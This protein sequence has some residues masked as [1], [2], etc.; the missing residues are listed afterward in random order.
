MIDGLFDLEEAGTNIRT[1]IVA[2]VT[3]FMTMSYIIFVQPAVL[4]AAGMNPGAVMVATCLSSAIAMV[5]MAVLTNYPIALAPAMGH[6]FF[7]SYIVVLTLGYTWQVAL[8]SVFIAGLV[9]ILL[10]TVGLRE[11]LMIVLPDCLKNGIP[12]GIGLL[13]ALVGLEW[14]GIVVGHQVTYVTLGNLKSAPTL[15]S[16]FGL[17]LIALL[18]ALKIRGAILF[19]IIATSILGLLVGIIEFEGVISAPPSIMPTM[20]KLQFPN[21][22]KDPNLLTVIFIFLFLDMFDT[23]G[24]LIGVGQQSGLMV[25]GKLPRARQALLTDAIST[26]AGA[27]LGTSTITAYIESASGISAGGRT[28]L[29]NIVTALLMVGAIF[30]HPIIEMVGAGYKINDGVTLYPVIA[31]ALIIV[32]GLMFKNIVN[33]DWDDFTESIPAFLTLIMMP[34]AFSITEGIS[35]G[36]ISYSLLKLCTGKR[37]EVHWLIYLFAILFIARYIWLME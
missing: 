31:P 4:G 28:G 16:V 10:S 34:L 37:K 18:L 32:G 35:I 30:F 23:I 13:I 14:S 21:V 27:L 7:F 11:K 25:D 9:F 5:L 15:V 33:V 3:T 26:S 6:N 29:A 2:G 17:L 1:E 20:L 8:G 36:V 22:V 19:G 12:V 24:T